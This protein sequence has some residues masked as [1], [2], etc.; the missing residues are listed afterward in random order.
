[1]TAAIS[2]ALAGTSGS[3]V[4]SS[5]RSRQ[6]G[7]SHSLMTSRAS[8][9]VSIDRRSSALPGSRRS[10]ASSRETG[11]SAV[12]PSAAAAVTTTCRPG[13]NDGSASAASAAASSA[14]TR[15]SSASQA[16]GRAFGKRKSWASMGWPGMRLSLTMATGSSSGSI[17]SG[18]M[19]WV[20][21]RSCQRTGRGSDSYPS[22]T[23]A[24]SGLMP[25]ISS[26]PCSSPMLARN[27]FCE[28]T[29]PGASACSVASQP[30]RG[31]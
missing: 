4:P 20:T 31:Q 6:P 26:S 16:R 27:R 10:S 17:A 30:G 9:G 24:F 18:A 1:M 15:S 22:T 12:K 3:G 23:A 19:T 14:T 2:P 11:S 13:S 5:S 29:R 21:P 25:R 28:S 7:R 8:R